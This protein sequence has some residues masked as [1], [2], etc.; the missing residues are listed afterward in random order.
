MSPSAAKWL[1]APGI[2]LRWHGSMLHAVD[3]RHNTV[4]GLLPS[5]SEERQRSSQH[6]GLVSVDQGS[7]CSWARGERIVVGILP[8]CDCLCVTGCLSAPTLPG[9]GP[10]AFGGR[11]R[12]GLDQ[13]VSSWVGKSVNTVAHL[14][15]KRL[16]VLAIVVVVALGA[17]GSWL[18]YRHFTNS[19]SPAA[20]AP[21]AGR[22]PTFESPDHTV[23]L[24]VPDDAMAPDTE[25]SFTPTADAAGD[26]NA[27]MRGVK[28]AGFPEEVHVAKGS[29]APDK[30]TMTLAYN[31]QLIPEGLSDKQVGLAIFDPYLDGWVPVLDAKADPKT[32]TV[33][34]VAPH[35]SL[36]SAIVLDPAKAV[37]NV[38]GKTI[39]TVIDGGTSIAQWFANLV[40][41]LTEAL[42][43]DLLGIAPPL[44]PKCAPPSSDVTVTAKSL[45]NRVGACAHPGDGKDV[46]VWLRNG[47]AF[48]MRI[49][50]LPS[51]M[52]QR[53][54]DIWN[55]GEDVVSLVRSAFWAKL[56][57]AMLSGAA[58]GSVTAT[59]NM[60][61][62]VDLTMDLDDDA[63][64]F[65]IALAFLMVV[66]PGQ[67]ALKGAVKQSA[68]AALKGATVTVEAMKPSAWVGEAFGALDCIIKQA[69]ATPPTD[70]YSHEGI[71]AAADVVYACLTDLLKQLNLKGALLDLLGVVKVLPETIESVVYRLGGALV[72]QMSSYKQEKPTVTVQRIQNQIDKTFV[73]PWQVHGT[74]LVINADGS[75]SEDW[76]DGPCTQS[77]SETR[78]CQGNA[79]IRFR[80][81]PDN[82]IIGVYARVWYASE[83][84]PAP[85]EHQPSDTDPKVGDTFW[86]VRNDAHTLRIGWD[87]PSKQ[88]LPGNPYFCDQYAEYHS[89]YRCGQ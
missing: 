23:K 59:S 20:A 38:A 10:A 58:L 29:L 50:K 71:K 69:H 67:A 88:N 86:L 83:G 80:S 84:G 82:K 4:V 43:N 12:V 32:Q 73:G 75:A 42:V 79:T 14:Q 19:T 54:G 55:S 62:S 65:D 44:D 49:E 78:L 63:V 47:Y 68:E 41:D 74:S 36:V 48:P 5:F 89:D 85:A 35:F 61:T 11:S 81:G 2:S 34:A 56:G 1:R 6:V 18:V 9:Q 37:V 76:N 26:L 66:A 8:N 72:E 40:K 51:G 3:C 25:V 46:T 24:M 13:S 39:K 87:D 33:T 60:K 15:P 64:A 30:V 21:P 45:L 16:W 52:V 28:A 7:S 31:P 77:V 57:Q 27:S 53:L 70:M 22:R 17:V